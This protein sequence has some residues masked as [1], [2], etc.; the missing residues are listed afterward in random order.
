MVG[1]QLDG[2]LSISIAR[3]LRSYIVI[4]KPFLQDISTGPKL[5]D[6]LFDYVVTGY[7]RDAGPW[8]EHDALSQSGDAGA[9]SNT[10]SI[11]YTCLR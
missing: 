4:T 3:R 10:L 8:F 7:I 9:C 11:A 2:V 1:H 6:M 5:K